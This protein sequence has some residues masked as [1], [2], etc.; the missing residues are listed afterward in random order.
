MLATVCYRPKPT[1]VI[2]PRQG[3]VVAYLGFAT[4]AAVAVI[5]P[6]QGGVVA[7]HKRKRKSISRV[8]IP[9]QGGVV[10][11]LRQLPSPRGTSYNPPPR[12]G[13]CLQ[14]YRGWSRSVCYN[15]PPRRG[16][17][18]QVFGKPCPYRDFAP[19]NNDFLL[20]ASGTISSVF[21]RK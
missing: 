19:P 4:T 7:Y 9:R 2:I 1:A 13:S 5:I 10:A 16:S 20:L 8:I 6:R 21:F 11:Y 15:P 12:R 3:G 18:L 17:C 14:R